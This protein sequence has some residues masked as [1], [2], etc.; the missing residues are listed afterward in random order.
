MLW[1]CPVSWCCQF[2]LCGCSFF[3][4]PG[5]DLSEDVQISMLILSPSGRCRDTFYQDLH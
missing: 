5:C 3:V 2:E 1:S 4:K